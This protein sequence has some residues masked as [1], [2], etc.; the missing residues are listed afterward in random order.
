MEMGLEGGGG[1]GFYEAHMGV[2]CIVLEGGGKR[3]T[4]GGI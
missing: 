1:D 2:G 3:M 4:W